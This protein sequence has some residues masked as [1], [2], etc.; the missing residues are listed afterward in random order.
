MYYEYIYVICLYI[1]YIYYIYACIY[2]CNMSI[3]IVHESFGYGHLFCRSLLTKL[4]TWIHIRQ[5]VFLVPVSV[6]C[7]FIGYFSAED[8]NQGA[9]IER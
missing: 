7:V 8:P 6:P 9:V 1:L 2:I 3:Y 4:Q 5:V